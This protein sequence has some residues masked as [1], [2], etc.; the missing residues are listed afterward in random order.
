MN[1]LILAF[2]LGLVVGAALR[3]R[4]IDDT[5]R[6]RYHTVRQQEAATGKVELGPT[7]EQLL[8]GGTTS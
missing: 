5:L 8:G 6:E 3:R 2:V 4:L 1:R 7:W